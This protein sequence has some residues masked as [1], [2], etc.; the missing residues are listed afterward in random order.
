[1]INN[2][3]LFGL[4]TCFVWLSVGVCALWLPDIPSAPSFVIPAIGSR[5]STCYSKAMDDYAIT[6][7]QFSLYFVW[8]YFPIDQVNILISGFTLICRRSQIKINRLQ[9]YKLQYYNIWQTLL[10]KYAFVNWDD[11][12]TYITHSSFNDIVQSTI[13]WA[14]MC[15]I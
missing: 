15:Y 8:T 13:Q 12:V 11:Y 2:S 6:W 10:V 9:K 7:K 5:L 4:N 14:I 1:M 3:G